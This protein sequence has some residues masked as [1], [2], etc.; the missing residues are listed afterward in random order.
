M[1]SLSEAL[2]SRHRMI[3]GVLYA[4]TIPSFENYSK[5]YNSGDINTSKARNSSRILNRITSTFNPGPISL[6]EF[7][8]SYEKI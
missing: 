8:M 2:A 7:E 6:E 3:K 1:S 4:V 5:Y